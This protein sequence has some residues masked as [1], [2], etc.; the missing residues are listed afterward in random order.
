ME[1]GYVQ[2]YTGNGKGK[3]TA[4]LG[5]ALRACGAGLRVYIGQF[6]KNMEYSEVT[7]IRNHL[8]TVEIEQYGA[9]CIFN[10]EASKFDIAEAEQG[11][12]KAR[13]AILSNRYDIVML[14]EINNAVTLGLLD[15]REVVKLIK[16][17]PLP[18]EL[19]L[20]GRGAAQE[21]IDE[22]DLVSE[23]AEMKHYYTSG[24]LAREG[25]ER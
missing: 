1:R 18:V 23:V 13:E 17:K 2:V 14:D 24:V 3:T 21:V 9:G 19:V 4:M 20:T 25:I 5:L 16:D 11:L 10:R 15:T 7:A 12:R 8:P 6:I 22:A